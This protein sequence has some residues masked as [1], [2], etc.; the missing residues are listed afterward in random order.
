MGVARRRR[1][2]LLFE[3]GRGTAIAIDHVLLA[4]ADLEEGGREVHRRWGLTALPGGRHPGAGTANLIVP[5][6]PDYLELI[7]IVDAVEAEGNPL[8]RRVTQALESGSTFA[9]WAVRVDDLAAVE[10]RLTAAGLSVTAPRDGSR[11]RP[12]GVLLRWRSLHLAGGLDPAL[13]FFI[14]WLVAPADHPGAREVTHPAGPVSLRRLVLSSPQP[15]GLE[16]RLRTILG[17]ELPL[18]VIAGEREEPVALLLDASG[19]EIE[20]R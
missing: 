2:R 7:A 12:D 15:R 13:P 18:D 1:P 8:S 20:L 16:E 3:E 19:R 14:E 17:G 4:V 10:R 6:G 11:L 5:L 9:T